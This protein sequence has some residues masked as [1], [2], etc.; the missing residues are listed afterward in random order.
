MKKLSV[1]VTSAALAAISFG[2]QGAASAA[3]SSPSDW[4]TGCTYSLDRRNGAKAKC[5]NSHGGHYKAT[6]FCSR[7]D[8]GD[9]INL[10]APVWRNSGWSYVFCPP[11]TT[12]HSAGIVTKAS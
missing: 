11:Q 9:L 12:Y 6:V 2:I 8:T 7:W 3:P 1:L 10:D 5:S 4:P